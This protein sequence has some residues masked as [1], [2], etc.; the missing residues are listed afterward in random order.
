MAEPDIKEELARM[1]AEPLLPVEKKLVGWSLA[2]G[3]VLLIL[4][5][6]ASYSFFPAQG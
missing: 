2:L 4:L 1:R 5:I 6:W 3:A